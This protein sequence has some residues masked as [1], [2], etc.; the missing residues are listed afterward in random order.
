[1]MGGM[2]SLLS[3]VGMSCVENMLYGLVPESMPPVI[4]S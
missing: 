4:S 2:P 3:G 1:M